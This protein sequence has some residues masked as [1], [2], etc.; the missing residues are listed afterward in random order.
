MNVPI[1]QVHEMCLSARGAVRLAFR[2]AQARAKAWEP[3][4]YPRR[5]NDQVLHVQHVSTPT[6]KETHAHH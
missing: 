4:P 3:L 5:A 6:R 1:D 2:E